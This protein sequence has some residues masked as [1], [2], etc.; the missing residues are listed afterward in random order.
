MKRDKMCEKIYC[1][2][3]R[4]AI[5]ILLLLYIIERVLTQEDRK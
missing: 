5:V 3:I 4:V 2:K 1:H